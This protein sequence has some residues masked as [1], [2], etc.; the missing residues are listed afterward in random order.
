MCIYILLASPALTAT[1]GRPQPCSGLAVWGH[2]EHNAC[3]LPIM[4]QCAI[5]QS[6][7][8]CG[9]AMPGRLAPYLAYTKSCE[10]RFLRLAGTVFH[11]F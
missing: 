10:K 5:E 7:H 9:C 8:T 11:S 4:T 1:A 3:R 2:C 6:F